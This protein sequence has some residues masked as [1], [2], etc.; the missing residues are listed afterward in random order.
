MLEENR[1]LSVDCPILEAGMG[2]TAHLEDLLLIGPHGAEAIHEVPPG[3]I[4]VQAGRGRVS[5]RPLQAPAAAGNQP[6]STSTSS[7]SPSGP[8]IS[9]IPAP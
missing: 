7:H 6:F 3:V 9:C 4:V 2:G 5:N 1:I 8:W